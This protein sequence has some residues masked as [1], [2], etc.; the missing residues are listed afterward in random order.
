MFEPT[1]TNNIGC[2]YYNRTITS[3][4]IIYYEWSNNNWK[5]RLREISFSN[6]SIDPVKCV[7]T[8]QSIAKKYNELISYEP[9]KVYTN[10]IYTYYKK[11]Y[12]GHVTVLDMN[13]AYLWVL[14]QPLADYTT[15]KE[16]T[17][18]EVWSGDYDYYCF[19]NK[20]HCEMFYYKDIDRMSGA[21]LWAGVKIYSYKSK[22][23]YKKTAKELYR[24]KCQVD[25]HRYK[26]VANIFVGCMHKKTGKQNNT[27][28]ASSLY[29]FFAW[30]IDNLVNMFTNANYSV[31]MVTTDSIKIKGNY[32]SNDK[33]LK[34]GKG[35]GDWKVE[36]VGEAEYISQG[37]Y[38]E[39]RV[40]WK[41]MTQYRI[42]GHKRLE[43]INN[44]DLEKEIYERY[45]VTT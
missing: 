12:K 8:F 36:Y 34:I 4:K 37:H 13:S 14:T 26:N 16:C 22:I 20:L 32:N 5:K 40:K 17:I 6:K 3:C 30:Y 23:Y 11:A 21:M 24:L 15:R 43:F 29:A 1:K 39:N 18:T 7:I 35:L 9:N 38:K 42:D 10:G 28:I 25:S 27:T 45:A 31:I 41:G 2:V 33:L 19:E 44:I